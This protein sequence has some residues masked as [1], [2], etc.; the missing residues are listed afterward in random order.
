M[1]AGDDKIHRIN[2]LLADLR[3]H[4][5]GA[6]EKVLESHSPLL[7]ITTGKKIPSPNQLAD[8]IGWA[9]THDK[10]AA[11][12]IN[13]LRQLL[14]DLKAT[15]VDMAKIV[16]EVASAPVDKNGAFIL[17]TEKILRYFNR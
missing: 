13:Q 10:P 9:L 16:V 12:K 2:L 4:H 7:R 1:G 11:P 15:D 5:P 3:A 17:F 14:Y 6:Y 8:A